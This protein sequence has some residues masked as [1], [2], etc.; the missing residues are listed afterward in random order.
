MLLLVAP[1][2][3]FGYDDTIFFGEIKSLVDKNQEDRIF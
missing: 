1:V 3:I 2:L